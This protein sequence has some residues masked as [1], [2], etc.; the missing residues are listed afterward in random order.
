MICILKIENNDI[1]GWF[2]AMDI[3]DAR[4]KA[5][6]SFNEELAAKLYTVEFP[7]PGKRD[8]GGGYTMLVDV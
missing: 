8:L 5:Q 6:G 1:K 3:H 2:T 7:R 4:R